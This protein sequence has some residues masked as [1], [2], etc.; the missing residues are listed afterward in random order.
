M[1]LEAIVEQVEVSKVPQ[2]IPGIPA[3]PAFRAERLS[4]KGRLLLVRLSQVLAN[5][6]IKPSPGM[7][8]RL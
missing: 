6:R 2:L 4:P 3:P 7:K 8:S 1:E 5:E